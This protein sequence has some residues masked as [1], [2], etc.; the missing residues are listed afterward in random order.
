M[1]MLSKLEHYIN[2][3]Q[4]RVMKTHKFNKNPVIKVKTQI[5]NESVL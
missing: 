3:K 1:S 4:L 2:V 5:F